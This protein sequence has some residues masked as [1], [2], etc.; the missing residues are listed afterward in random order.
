MEIDCFWL[1]LSTSFL[2]FRGLALD[3]A[4]KIFLSEGEFNVGIHTISVHSSSRR[5]HPRKEDANC[6]FRRG[7]SSV[8]MYPVSRSSR[9][10]IN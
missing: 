1:D 8:M 4:K 5:G 3:L 9:Y 10:V 7:P 2:D 6:I